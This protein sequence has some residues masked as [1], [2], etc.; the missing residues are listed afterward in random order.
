R[1]KTRGGI[2]KGETPIVRRRVRHFKFL[3]SGFPDSPAKYWAS[4][5]PADG[6]RTSARR[7]RYPLDSTVRDGFE[8]LSETGP[9]SSSDARKQWREDATLYGSSARADIEP[10]IRCASCGRES[11]HAP[12]PSPCR[13][14]AERTDHRSDSS[15]A[16]KAALC[17]LR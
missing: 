1:R 7:A 8:V 3:S 15:T 5:P 17:G 10:G 16:G 11:R 14:T 4:A 13:G 9:A 12:I 6:G 2:M